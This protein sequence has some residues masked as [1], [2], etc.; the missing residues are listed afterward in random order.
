MKRKQGIT[1]PLAPLDP[2]QRYSIPEAARYL[3]RAQ[4]TTW[5]LIR[6]GRIRVLREM[7]RCYVPGHEIVRL[8]RLPDEQ[9]SAA[10]RP[11]A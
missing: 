4:S 1:P 5:L 11:A 2:L 3:R 6:E 7:G 9:D 10:G 8:S